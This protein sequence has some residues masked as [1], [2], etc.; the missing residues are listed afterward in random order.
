VLLSGGLDS[1]TTL[2]LA[3]DAGFEVHALAFR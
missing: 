3:K 2:A 1:T